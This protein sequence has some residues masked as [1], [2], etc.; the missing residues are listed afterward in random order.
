MPLAI[1]IETAHGP[2]GVV[3]ADAPDTD[4]NVSIAMLETGAPHVV[5]T[6]LLGVDGPEDEVY[7]HRTRPVEGLRALV[8]GHF[9]VGEVEQA[10]NRWNIDTGA[11]FPG[12]G[13]LT[14]LHVNALRLRPRTFDT[15]EPC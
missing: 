15:V 7:R 2:V 11:S 4:W 3:H 6:T 14:L 12:R 8:H 10:A 9:V 13:R 1:T 5:D